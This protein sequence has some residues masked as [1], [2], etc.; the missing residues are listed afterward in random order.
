MIYQK[1]LKDLRELLKSQG[2]D[3]YIVPRTDEYQ[4]EF[5]PPG[6]ERLQWLTGFTGSAGVAVVLKDAAV[7]MTDSRYTLQARGQIDRDLYVLDDSMKKQLP[8][9]VRENIG[10]G[11]VIGY[12][13]MLHTVKQ[14]QQWEQ[15]GEEQGQRY[16]PVPGNLIDRLWRDR[17]GPPKAQAFLFPDDVAGRSAA[18]KLALVA[19]D[20]RVRNV[21]AALLTRQ[22][23]IAWL[24]NVRGGDVDCTP[25]VLSHAIVRADAPRVEWFVEP[26]KIPQDVAKALSTVADI[27][28]AAKLE[29]R[30]AILAQAA[31]QAGR[32]I[33]L[34][35]AATPVYFQTQL[36]QQGAEIA[37]AQDPCVMP[38]ACKTAAE[39]D[40]IRAA[41]IRDGVAVTRF[42]HA[43]AQ[44]KVKDEL[45]AA[46]KITAF[47]AED[48]SFRGLSFPV[49]AGF[50]ANGAVVHY[51]AT[52]QTNR[53]IKA[54]GLLLIDSGGQYEWGT[55]D[56]TRTV[57]IGAPSEEMRKNFT[58]VLKGHIAVA[59]ARFPAGTKGVEID[60]L[61]RAPLK[62]AGL[63]YGHGT[64]HGV[65]CFLGVHEEA[66]SISPR[67]QEPLRPGMLISNEP[68]YYQEGAYGI[69]IENLVMVRE[70]LAGLSFETVTLAP[71]DRSLIDVSLL[72]T[73]ERE[74]LN[75]YHARVMQTLGPLLP[76]D[77]REW[78]QTETAPL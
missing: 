60:A 69:R 28:P 73:E 75:A 63:D 21:L 47:R 3:G 61:A 65:G 56:I 18:D 52:A 15:T 35:P 44:G 14:I 76:A 43:L 59:S 66:A 10:E 31:R 2:L 20:L 46:D 37:E 19:A 58:L 48:A 50:N 40:S 77:V 55:T 29:E 12:D 72:S 53:A 38:K 33:A 5:V 78:L 22:D 17:P 23:S 16:K 39:L 67:G 11:A 4:N 70:A 25:L 42:L 64:G 13:P 8:D 7:L 36:K 9:W 1:R 45:D 51:R 24:L 49:I 71:I 68:G 6:A 62:A 74:W 57:A 30:L 34:D 41:H 26:E 27:F 54:P 32:G